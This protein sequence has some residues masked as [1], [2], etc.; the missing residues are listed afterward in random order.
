[1]SDHISALHR[2]LQQQKLNETPNYSISEPVGA[3]HTPIYERCAVT[4]CG[5]EYVVTGKF[6]K[7]K[8]AK[9]AA[10]KQALISLTAE[11]EVDEQIYYNHRNKNS[12]ECYLFD[13]DNVPINSTQIQSMLRSD[14]EVHM[15]YSKLRGD[16]ELQKYPALQLHPTTPLI[17]EMTDHCISWW[18]CEQKDR[19]LKKKTKVYLISRDKGIG[20]IAHLAKEFGV[21]IEHRYQI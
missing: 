1:M 8:D 4:I 6:T 2:W 19:L 7:H 17:P 12:S 10:A 13:L 11:D 3:P 9:Q 5:K 20:A 16:I 21:D 14:C 15:F 18:V